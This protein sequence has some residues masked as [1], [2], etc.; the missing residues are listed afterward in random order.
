MIR[1]FLTMA[2]FVSLASGPAQAQTTYHLLTSPGDLGWSLEIQDLAT[3]SGVSVSGPPG[4]DLEV[5]ANRADGTLFVAG[6]EFGIGTFDPVNENFDAHAPLGRDFASLASMTFDQDGTLWCLV[7]LADDG[8][9]SVLVSVDAD[10]GATSAPVTPSVAVEGLAEW[11]GELFTTLAADD[12]PRL[13]VLNPV[14]GTLT[15]IGQIGIADF[16]I[17]TLAADPD[18]NQLYGFGPAYVSNP[19]TTPIGLVSLDPVT[20]EGVV[21]DT[22]FASI[23]MHSAVQYSLAVGPA[24]GAATIPTTGPLGMAALI[25]FLTLS[26]ILFLRRSA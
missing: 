6:A 5:L 9:D 7:T 22:S 17:S 25:L 4:V 21:L 8:S 1:S 20:A 19:L 18:G 3:G 10:T 12:Q 15:V 14:S 2:L 23:G 24:R 26:A 16:R 11:Q 13:A